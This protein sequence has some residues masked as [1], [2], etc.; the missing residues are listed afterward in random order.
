MKKII[1]FSIIMLYFTLLCIFLTEKT[2]PLSLQ[3]LAWQ[4]HFANKDEITWQR[5]PYPCYYEI[6]TF[7]K[8][9]ENSAVKEQ[10]KLIKRSFTFNNDFA[11]PTALIPVYYRIKAFGL[12]GS[13][14]QASSFKGD[15]VFTGSPLKPHPIT[16]YDRK[17]PAS[18]KPFLIWHTVPNAVYY[19]LEILSGPPDDPEG[20][21]LSQKNHLYSTQE[22]F[23]HGYQ[24]DLTTF[25]KIPQ[26]F[27]RVR[28]LNIYGRPIG[29][30][31]HAQPIYVD[32]NKPYPVSPLIDNYDAIA[33]ETMPLYPVY[34]WL[35]MVNVSR[36]EI[37]LLSNIPLN[38]NPA[39]I[40]K[41]HIKTLTVDGLFT[42]YDTEALIKSGTYYWRVRGLSSTGQPIGLWSDSQKII[43]PSPKD[44][45]VDVATFGDSIT[46]G[47]GNLSYSPANK[48]YNYQLYLDFP[49][50]NLAKS[51]DTVKMALDRFDKD[52]LPF[53]PKNLLILCGTNSIRNETIAAP[54]IIDNLKKLRQKCL[55]NNIR[56][57]FITLPPLNRQNIKNSFHTNTDPKWKDKLVQV[58]GYILTLPYHI[59]IEPYFYDKNGNLADIYS[60]DGLHPN[61]DGKKLMA[62]IINQHKDLFIWS[63]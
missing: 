8:N 19:E 18:Y 59:D 40:D 47:G 63:K 31:S 38:N 2:D 13:I 48:E 61:L 28:A 46:H 5:L 58:N 14:G 17:N 24:V 50:V 22:I 23:T 20:I 37:E 9:P 52:V 25:K 42:C 55:D 30:F 16:N 45:N 39:I 43:V 4:I 1:V 32:K 3:K 54:T 11:P 56:P 12:F 26:L 62:D 36:Y 44:I 6:D 10:Y 49:T 60:S 41:S 35:P 27:W 15:P 7:I 34:H 29:I 53:A 33:P 51:G 21:S 57:V